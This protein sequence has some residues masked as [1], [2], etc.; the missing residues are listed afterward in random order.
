[1]AFDR[2][3]FCA[4]SSQANDSAPRLWMYRT[5]D[6]LADCNTAGYFNSVVNEVNVGDLIY[7]HVDTDGTPAYVLLPVVSNDG[8][9]VDVS[10][11]TSLE[12]TDTD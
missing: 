5:T 8:S 4:A 2:D 1:M 11:G 3:N 10:D 6:T 7:A 12:T 9:A